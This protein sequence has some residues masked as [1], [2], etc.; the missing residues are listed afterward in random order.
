MRILHFACGCLCSVESHTYISLSDRCAGGRP[1][2]HP[3]D[4]PSMRPTGPRL[5]PPR[6]TGPR[7]WL[8]LPPPLA[9][10]CSAAPSR[11]AARGWDAATSLT[12]RRTGAGPAPCCGGLAQLGGTDDTFGVGSGNLLN[13]PD[14]RTLLITPCLWQ[15]AS[16]HTDARRSP[17]SVPINV[18]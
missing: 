15:V 18:C 6:S 8:E 2:T 12:G 9:G 1:S 13:W 10:V 5:P 17:S 4:P 14:P 3:P 7:C 11:G 16:S